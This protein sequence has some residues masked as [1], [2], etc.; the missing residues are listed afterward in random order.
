MYT[1][2]SAVQLAI[3]LAAAQ[4]QQI[5]KQNPVIALD[6]YSSSGKSTLA[7]DLATLLEITHIDTGAMYRATAL[8][9]LQTGISPDDEPT[10]TSSLDDIDIE[11]CLEKGQR[12]TKLNDIDVSEEIRSMKVSN[13]VSEVSTISSVRRYLVKQQRKIAASQSV[14]MDGRDIGTVVLPD[15]DVKIFVTASIEERS[16]RRHLELSNKGVDISLEEVST[17]LEKRDRIDSGRKDSPLLQADDAV[18]LD[19]TTYDRP[20]M[21]VEAIKI[22]SNKLN[23]HL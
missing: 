23:A 17:N 4:I 22:I 15:A 13:I 1:I 8:Y 21:L 6:G 11:L 2:P 5:K 18:L 9:L 16:K 14:V 10:V 20:G 19:T 12:C 7:K 3:K